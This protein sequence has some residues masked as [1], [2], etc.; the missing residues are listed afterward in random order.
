MKKFIALLLTVFLI[1]TL[2]ACTGGTKSTT[3]AEKTSTATKAGQPLNIGIMPSNASIPLVLAKQN[4][5]YEQEGVNVNIQL[6]KSAQ[7]RNSAFQSGNLD[8]SI[9]DLLAVALAKDGGFEVKATSQTNGSYKLVVNGK[10]DIKDI[11]GLKGKNIA[12]STN[13]VIEYSTDAILSDA[14]VKPDEVNKIAVPQIP[15]R[16]EMLQNGNVDAATLPEPMASVAIGNGARLLKD[17]DTLDVNPEVIMFTQS[18]IDSKTEE[19]KAFYRAYNRAVEYAQKENVSNYMDVLIK[20]VSFP[21]SVRDVLVLPDF[22][23]AAL[24]SEK[25]C[26]SVIQWL[27]DKKLIKSTYKLDDLVDSEF[28]R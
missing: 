5:Y 17:S 2:A 3:E 9:S 21:D 10:S 4:G 28:V 12:I 6:F 16:L 20:E 15:V 26:D 18:S 8:G 27:K 25:D 7:D 13:T 1:L 22:K 24:P 19:I 23:K 14:D 11:A